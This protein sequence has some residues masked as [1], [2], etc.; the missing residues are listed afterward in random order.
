MKNAKLCKHIALYAFNPS[1]RG[2]RRYQALSLLSCF[3]KNTRLIS[4]F[5]ESEDKDYA[6]LE[7]G[8]LEHTM[9]VS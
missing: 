3:Y 2:F 6:S 8:I 1:V 4:M 7:E 9:N 5:K